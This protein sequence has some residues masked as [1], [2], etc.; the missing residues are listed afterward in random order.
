MKK[1]VFFAVFV[2]PLCLACAKTEQAVGD[3]SIQPVNPGEQEALPADLQPREG[4]TTED[5][6]PVVMVFGAG[7]SQDK[8][9]VP[10]PEQPVEEENPS[11]TEE[12]NHEPEDTRTALSYK[13]ATT[14]YNYWSDGDRVRINGVSSG[15]LKTGDGYV[16]TKSARFPMAEV[17]PQYEDCWYYGF[18]ADQFTFAEGIGTITIPASQQYVEGSYDPRAFIMVG[19]S[20]TQSLTFYPKV[21]LI[22]ITAKDATTPYDYKIAK[23]R[24]E[25]IGGEA[26]S[27]TFTTDYNNASSTFTAASG[28]AYVEINAP[29]GGLD[30]GTQFFFCVPAGRYEKGLRFIVYA[31]DGTSMTFSNTASFTAEVGTAHNIGSPRY[32]ESPS[33]FEDAPELGEITSSTLF[34]KWHSHA[35]D[36]DYAKRW[37]IYVSTSADFTTGVREVEIYPKAGS[38]NDK[39][40][41]LTFTVGRLNPGARYYVKVLDVGNHI[42]TPVSDIT[43]SASPISQTMPVEDIAATGMILSE[44]FSEIGWGS[45]YYND[46]SYGGFYPT[47]SEGG[48][49][50]NDRTFDYLVADDASTFMRGGADLNFEFSRFDAAYAASRLNGWLYQGSTYFKNGFMKLGKTGAAGYLLTPPILLAEG[51]K[52]EVKV[53]VKAAKFDGGTASTWAI[54]VVSGVTG[55]GRKTSAD[56][57][58]PSSGSVVQYRTVTIP[59]KTWNEVT[60]E[61]LYAQDGDRIVFGFPQDVAVSGTNARAYLGYLSIEVTALTDDFIIHDE[62][63][64]AAFNAAVTG[65]DTDL[66]ARVACDFNVGSTAAAAWTPI[67]G[68][69]GTLDGNGKTITGLTSP[70]FG[71]LQGTVQDLTLNSTI[72]Q[73]DDTQYTAIFAERLNGT[74]SYCTTQ[75]SVIFQPSTAVTGGAER[76]VAGMVGRVESG[77][78]FH[79]TNQASVSFPDN[80]E[81]NDMTINIGGAVASMESSTASSYVSNT[82]TLSVGIVNATSSNRTGRIGG[83]VGN[84]SGN[85]VSYFT[86]SGSVG[87]TGTIHGQMYMG[88]IVGYTNQAVSDCEN[89]GTV[90]A[91]GVMNSSASNHYRCVAGIVGWEE[92]DVALD[93]N[94]N[95]A[96]AVISNS[97]TSTGYTLIGGIVGYNKGT[98]SG[99]GNAASVSY[100]GHSDN[101]VCVGGIV[102]RTISGKSGTCIGGSGL[103]SNSGAIRLSES[104]AHSNTTTVYVGGISAHQGSG[105]VLAQNLGAISVDG[106]HCTVLLVGGICGSGAS[107]NSYSILS[108]SSNAST[109]GITLSG[110]SAEYRTELDPESESYVN[111]G[112]NIYV[113]GLS[114]NAYGNVAGTNAGNISLDNTCSANGFIYVGGLCGQLLSSYALGLGSYNVGNVSNACPTDGACG[115]GSA[116]DIAVG[117]L[118]GN[119][120]SSTSFSSG[121]YNE[122]TVDNSASASGG[123]ARICVGGLVGKAQGVTMANCHNDG[124][125]SNSGVGGD[126]T[127][128]VRLGGL[129]GFATGANTL[130][131]TSVSVNNYNNAAIVETSSS[132]CIAVG[133]VVGYADDAGTDLAYCQNRSDGDV[134]LGK[135]AADCTHGTVYAGGVLACTSASTQFDYASNAGDI[136]FS[137]LDISG[138]VFAGGV[139][140]AFTASGPQTITGCVNSG[141]IKTK[142]TANNTHLKSSSISTRWSFFGGISAVGVTDATQQLYAFGDMGKTFASCTN[143]GEIGIYAAL[144]SCV[145]G[146]LA[147]SEICPSGAVCLADIRLYKNEGTSGGG[148][149]ADYRRSLC[150]GIIG[151]CPVATLSGL[152][153]VGTLNSSSSSPFAY[154]GGIVGLVNGNTAFSTCKVGGSIRAAGSASG[155]AGLFCHNEGSNTYSFTDCVLKTDTKIYYQSSTAATVTDDN[156]AFEYFIANT[157]GSL[158]GSLPIIGSID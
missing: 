21:S 135:D 60:V 53:K 41:P 16:G 91:G 80:N 118:V 20:A 109:A 31:K 73:T 55:S 105:D 102:G 155:S 17:V 156:K 22:R 149:G 97:G 143:T 9:P 154:T 99:G 132:D 157:S 57:T 151:Y 69:T 115:V 75:G 130:A 142:T 94:I 42:F 35:T 51:K 62:T 77:S 92:G 123:S 90:T 134:M 133:G 2:L 24:L 101:S 121:L 148:T 96:T 44:N 125:V 113:G 64:L 127:A 66:N 43:L 3:D 106:L 68:Y 7:I 119:A 38:W 150:G 18:P 67:D 98:I 111:K 108:G 48:T 126:A 107:N 114:G 93:R 10:E 81:T 5:G 39:Q 78:M 139:H 29:D 28:N 40:T 54:A 82:G 129:V 6:R 158:S 103:V 122:G 15:A 136:V 84:L 74:M 153:Y 120:H 37:R 47:T 112:G 12:L 71:N 32:S 104:S 65:G 117:G 146:V 137:R 56:F 89:S 63:T 131:G 72:N 87:L 27:G 11:D 100:T 124:S 145:G 36:N 34:V 58:W 95:T 85:A 79:C 76:Y 50:V 61:G 33:T 1:S 128:G 26:L 83:V 14:Y 46:V 13:D 140:G 45:A 52:A 138:Q 144:R 147:R 86:N 70:F 4:E 19:K 25:S 8:Q 152:K 59:S 49:S 116:G 88:G 30:F 23:V 110:V 141:A